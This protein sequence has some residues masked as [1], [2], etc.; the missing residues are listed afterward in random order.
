MRPFRRFFPVAIAVA[1]V[2]PNILPAQ[3]IP[4][5]PPTPGECSAAIVALNSGSPTG[6]GWERIAAC[7]SA[8]AT[9]VGHALWNA[10]ASVDTVYLKALYASA[11][12]MRHPTILGTAREV[13]STASASLDARMMNLLLL[14]SQVDPTLSP[15]FSESWHSFVTVPMGPPCTLRFST[16][17]EYRTTA[18]L[19]SD[20]LA[21]IAATV[22]PI[23]NGSSAPPVL[24]DLARCVHTIISV[25]LP[26]RVR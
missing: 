6:A 9:A 10:R 18:A 17:L 3:I 23:M 12:A 7:G 20:Y 5:P 8:G 15:R 4:G 19:P 14:A 22:E 21:R 26:E 11:S 24:R 2:L 1:L 25:E 13:V 16:D